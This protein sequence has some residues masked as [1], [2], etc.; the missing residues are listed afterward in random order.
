MEYLQG[1]ALTNAVGN[2]DITGAYAEAVKKFGYELE[3]LVTE[4]SSLRLTPM[5]LPFALPNSYI[6]TFLSCSGR[7]VTPIELANM[8][9]ILATMRESWENGF[10]VAG[11][12]FASTNQNGGEILWTAEKNTVPHLTTENSYA[13]GLTK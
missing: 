1:R 5:E 3:A 12:P 11:L 6:A 4:V 7:K 8:V 2:L 13:V 9:A 10:V